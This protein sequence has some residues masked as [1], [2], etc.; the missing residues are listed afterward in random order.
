MA[1]LMLL[2]RQRRL[3]A[4][5]VAESSTFVSGRQLSTTTRATVC[6]NPTA[7]FGDR[8]QTTGIKSHNHHHHHHQAFVGSFPSPLNQRH[9]RQA[10]LLATT[11]LFSAAVPDSTTTDNDDDNEEGNEQVSFFSSQ[12]TDFASLGIQ[13]PTLLQRLENLRLIR[14]TTVQAKAFDD[15]SERLTDVTVGA[16]TG[17]GKTLA[18]LLPL[19]D[20]ILQ[21]KQKVVDNDDDDDDKATDV[22]YDFARAIILVPNKELVQQVIRMALPL[23]GGPTALVYGGNTLADPSILGMEQKNNS[24]NNKDDGNADEST[25]I[26]LAIMPGGLAEPVDFPPFRNA[27]RGSTPP[28]DL[29]VTTPASIGPMALK[30]KNIDMF[31]DVRTLVVDEA[32][33]LLDGGFIKALE[34]VLMGFRRADKLTPNYSKWSL[35]ETISATDGDDDESSFSGP[36]RTQHVFV[37][38]TLPDYGKRSVDAYLQK[39]FP[40]AKRVEAA[41]MHKARHSGLAS[42][43]VWVA[44]E[45]KRARMEEL[46]RLLSTSPS[47]GG[48]QK[49]KVMIFLNKVNEVQGACDALIRA[50]FDAVPYH[51]KMTLPER[52]NVLNRF[53]K[54]SQGQEEGKKSSSVPLLVCTDLA[55]RGLD[56]P[57]VTAVVQL[58]FAGNV[59]AHLH[60]MGRTGRAGQRTGRGFVF[61]SKDEAELIEV[62][63][64][65]E[66][67]QEG[68]GEAGSG[69]LTL[70]GPEV[71]DTPDQLEDDDEVGNQIQPKKPHVSGT[72]NKAFSRNRSFKNKIKQRRRKERE[73]QEHSSAP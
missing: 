42:E 35:N 1:M 5:A 71:Q 72:I 16:E 57:G 14:P 40:R 60:R 58:Q 31:A 41:G 64:Q 34:Q 28:V 54:Y 47:E 15:I 20:D 8:Q 49:E 13:S 25:L 7:S 73:E 67:E 24:N 29:V 17:S 69:E 68:R 18:Y 55:A 2:G 48:L 22:G 9:Q 4:A 37:A 46:V 66:A 21:R 32:D 56:V 63:R 27:I 19:M 33:M 23:A 45:S 6:N 30:T 12:H 44:E 65:A 43:T 39:K 52:V 3:V 59:V 53:R 11:R 36:E 26:R 38:A 50:G 70:E 51:A 61:Y 10:S 62:V